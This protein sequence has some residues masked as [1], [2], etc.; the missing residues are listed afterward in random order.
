MKQNKETLKKYFETGDKPTQQQYAELIDSYVDSKQPEGKANRRFVIDETGEVNIA[1]EE[2][3]PEYTLSDIVNNKL[4]LLKDGITVKEIDLTPYVDDT[5]LARLVSGTVDNN[6]V[7]TFTRDDNS[8][9]TVDLSN[10]KGSGAVDVSNLVPYTGATQDVDLGDHYLKLGKERTVLNKAKHKDLLY[11]GNNSFLKQQTHVH[12]ET[13]YIDGESIGLGK[14]ALLNNTGINV[15][16][17]GISAAQNNTGANVVANGNYAAQNNTGNYATAIGDFALRINTGG[18]SVG[19]GYSSG[20]G[21]TG[22]SSVFVGVSSGTSNT[23]RYTTG[24]GYLAARSNKGAFST[25]VGHSALALNTHDGSTGVGYQSGESNTGSLA[26]FLGFRAGHQ[27]KGNNCI[28][29]GNN[30]LSSNASTGHT[31]IAIGNNALQYNTGYD[32]VVVGYF[33]GNKNIGNRIVGLGN[34][35]L[36]ENKGSSVVAIG[37]TSARQN[38]GNYAIGIGDESIVN[39]TGNDVMGV[40]YQSLRYNSGEKNI[41]LGVRSW[42]NF[43]E[44]TTKSK[45]FTAVE[46]DFENN[47]I[48]VTNHGFGTANSIVNL[49]FR[50]TGTAPTGLPNGMI[51][52]FKVID[53][54]TLEAVAQNIHTAGTGSHTFIPQFIYNNTTVIGYNSQPTKSN[55]VVLGSAATEEVTTAKDYKSTG[56]GYGVILKTPDGSKDFRISIDNSGNVVTTQ[57]V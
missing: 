53:A 11:V 46:V 7:A 19:V 16:G 30:A 31:P 44:D 42:N 41:A 15:V 13:D 57:V 20:A 39:N 2:R 51:G 33:S 9:F 23:G 29:I 36:S 5:N 56:S 25:A 55:Q 38:F 34:S 52:S 27:N 45:S 37:H 48:T 50:T 17:T 40:G 24:I 6:G 32:S 10:L 12:N 49:K 54:N 35:T 3:T 8:T 43:V 47:R 18:S 14:K 28:A 21:N 22:D 26:T 4:S 1:E